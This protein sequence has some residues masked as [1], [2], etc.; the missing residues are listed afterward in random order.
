M[1]LQ[2]KTAFVAGGST[3]IGFA[4]AKD[5]VIEG[6]NVVIFARNSDKLTD[7]LHQIKKY[8]TSNQ[9]VAAFSLDATD[10]EAVKNCFNNVIEKIGAPDILINCVGIAQ[11]HNFEQITYQ[12]F[13][14]TIHTNLYS[15]WNTI[16]AALPHMKKKGGHILNTSSVAGYL[17][18]FGYTDYCM[19]KF[20][21]IGFSEALRQELHQYNIKV[22]I[23]CPPDTDTPGLAEENKTKPEETKAIGGKAK[24][25]QPEDISKS[26][27][28]ALKNGDKLILPGFDSK[29]TWILK[30]FFPSLAERIMMSAV[31]K[32]QKQRI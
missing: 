5:L 10:N 31:K 20:G 18:V 26:V 11:P 8:A 3:G 30:R 21:I 16:A 15:M 9:K 25:M 12:S 27:I 29:M 14:K 7:A 17:G 22:S 2:H 32:V 4:I 23:L 6:A 13:D 28:S 24:L 19:T 1:S